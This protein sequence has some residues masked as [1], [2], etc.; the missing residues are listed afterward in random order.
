MTN[1]NDIKAY[2]KEY[3]LQMG[4]KPDCV[5]VDYLDEMGS[6]NRSIKIDN[7]FIKDQYVTA[8]LRELAVELDIIT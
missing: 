2:L 6:V 3:E 5:A 7:L 1:V 8:E 4:F